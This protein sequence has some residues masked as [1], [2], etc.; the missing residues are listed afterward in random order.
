MNSQY[1]LT[2]LIFLN[3]NT[4]AVDLAKQGRLFQISVPL[5]CTEFVPHT[6]DFAMV[7]TS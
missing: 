4:E 5:K 2:S 3:S 7:M 1:F 6:V